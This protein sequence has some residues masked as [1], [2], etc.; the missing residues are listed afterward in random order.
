[1][2]IFNSQQNINEVY[3]ESRLNQNIKR[4]GSLVDNKPDGQWLWYYENGQIWRKEDYK[5]GVLHGKQITYHQ[6]GSL[7]GERNFMNGKIEG[8]CYL[9]YPNG[10]L[11]NEVTCK[12]DKRNGQHI[13]YYEDGKIKFKMNFLNEEI[14]GEFLLYHPNGNLREECN[15]KR[16]KKNG[17]I[18]QYYKSNGKLMVD[19]S[20]TDGEVDDQEIIIYNNDGSILSSS[21]YQNKK[22]ISYGIGNFSEDYLD[23]I[24]FGDELINK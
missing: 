9:Y 14:E 11:K 5:K 17:K 1:M 23:T 13:E 19:F 3:F 15:F 6:N 16:N 22:M 4:V 21:K 18:R 10:K 20:V 2:G 12:D 24:L 8:K 7:N